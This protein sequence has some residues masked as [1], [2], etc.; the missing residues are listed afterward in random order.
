MVLIIVQTG[1]MKLIVSIQVFKIKSLCNYYQ[2]QLIINV[3]YP[4][5]YIFNIYYCMH[6]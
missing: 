3:S 1:A 4:K 6:K 2:L 5:H